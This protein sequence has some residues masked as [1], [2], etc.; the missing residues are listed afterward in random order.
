AFLPLAAAEA[1]DLVEIHAHVPRLELAALV[2]DGRGARQVDAARSK[3][4]GERGEDYCGRAM[5]SA[6]FLSTAF[7]SERA[8]ALSRA[9]CSTAQPTMQAWKNATLS[10]SVLRPAAPSTGVMRA[11]SS[12]TNLRMRCLIFGSRSAAATRPSI[13]RERRLSA[14]P[15]AM[16]S[17]T[18]PSR[19]CASWP[20][21]FSI[22]WRAISC[23]SSP[24]VGK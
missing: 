12:A 8:C 6:A 5:H 24:R 1:A 20:A 3:S 7:A 16:P 22:E 9:S 23:R 4:Y 13:T 11:R 17:A 18:V 10:G 15:A 14:A 2:V 21:S 19:A